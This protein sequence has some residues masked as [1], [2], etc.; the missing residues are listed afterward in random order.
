LNYLQDS[1]VN[2]NFLVIKLKSYQKLSLKSDYFLKIISIYL[3]NELRENIGRASDLIKEF[4]DQIVEPEILVLVIES[5]I[6]FQLKDL[7]EE[8][9]ELKVDNILQS[10]V[11]LENHSKKYNLIFSV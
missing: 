6:Q 2:D 8:Y 4:K 5:L 10:I 11:A 7:G 3:S 9:S 1:N